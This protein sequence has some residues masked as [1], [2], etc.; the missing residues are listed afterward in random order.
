MSAV[1]QATAAINSYNEYHCAG[2]PRKAVPKLAATTPRVLAVNRQLQQLGKGGAGES[3]SIGG[4]QRTLAL[5]HCHTGVGRCGPAPLRSRE[6]TAKSACYIHGKGRSWFLCRVILNAA[7][8]FAG[9]A[10]AVCRCSYNS[11]GGLPLIGD[12]KTT[13]GAPSALLSKNA[14]PEGAARFGDNQG[15]IRS[16]FGGHSRH[17]RE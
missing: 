1:L 16:T 13:F 3:G 2:Y 9:K 15:A 5:G 17:R 7:G 6:E 11:A 12:H 8:F 14:G 4:T 10:S